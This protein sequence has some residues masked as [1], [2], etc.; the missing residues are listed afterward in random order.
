[1]FSLFRGKISTSVSENEFRPLVLREGIVFAVRN[2]KQG[3]E[4]RGKF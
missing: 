3:Y 4:Q 2:I 1:V